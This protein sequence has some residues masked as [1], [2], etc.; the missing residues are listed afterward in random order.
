MEE[1]WSLVTSDPDEPGV[2]AVY[3][4]STCGA[5]YEL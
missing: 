5:T 1:N 4:C 3:E 2:E